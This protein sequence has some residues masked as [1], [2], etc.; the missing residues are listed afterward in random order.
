[1]TG[2]TKNRGPLYRPQRITVELIRELDKA[3]PPPTRTD[4]RDRYAGLILTHMRSGKLSLY[5]NLGRAKRK[6]IC[7]ARQIIN[8]HSSW[9]LSKAKHEAQR[10]RGLQL[11]G[12][13][14]SA[15]RRAE[16]AIPT[17]DAYLR[18]T[19]GPWLLDNRRSGAE[20]LRKLRRL[21]DD[22]GR[23][24]L[25]ELTPVA[26]EP[27]RAKR[28]REVQAE[29]VLKDIGS[30]R[31]ALSRAVR[32]KI[33][34][35][36]PLLGVETPEI[37]RHKRVVRALTAA[38][39]AALLQALEARDETKRQK[40][41]SAN[42]WRKE[43]GRDPLPPIGR[44]AD[45]LT[46]AVIVSLETGLRRGEL[47]ALEWPAVDLD[48]RI[49]RVHGPTSKTYET[50]DI[51]LNG[52]AYTTLR[53]WW[54]QCGQPRDGLVFTLDGGRIGSLK[55][56]Y[57]AVLA[58]AG[59][60]RVNRRGERVNWHSLRHTFGTLLG[61]AGCDPVTLQRLMGHADLA[62]TQR[63]LHTDEERKR[64]AVE[65]LETAQ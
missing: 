14:F 10:L 62:T 9:T 58:A 24:K 33:I 63:Y 8:E 51:P 22:L 55:R 32:W 56:S 65:L 7:D 11:D 2:N 46:P 53:D 37:D 21:A 26:L 41:A 60:E 50:R 48:E 4:I 29:T 34:P 12:R 52:L 23:Y 5:A 18:D 42:R 1:M 20:T 19:Y 25:S 3:P 16:R 49:V 17:L 64:A 38:E 6:L 35:Q 59:I 54:L 30:L 43:R 44:F 31:A 47:L 15:E 40:R 36:N 39:K 28:R 45:V 27:W 13:D 57:H 61:A